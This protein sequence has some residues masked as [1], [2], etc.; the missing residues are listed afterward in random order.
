MKF[1]NKIKLTLLIIF[2]SLIFNFNI[3]FSKNIIIEGNNFIDDEVI[4]SIIGENNFDSNE[5]YINNILK[6]LYNTGNFKNIEIDETSDSIII[7]IEENSRINKISFSGNKRFK[8]D[9]I[10]DQFSDSDYFEF[11]NE[12]R[13]D[14]FINDLK[15]LYLSY[16]YNQIQIEY[17]TVK[18]NDENNSI[19]LIFSFSEGKI[20]KINK[21]FFIGSEFFTKRDFLSEIK[22]NER[23]YFYLFRN[24]NY[25]KFQIKNDLIKIKNFYQKNGFRDVNINYKSEYLESKNRFNVYFYIEE[26]QRY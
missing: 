19:E 14:K 13:I 23:N 22:S 17:K 12:I 18:N 15:N 4:Y 11:Y 9:I 10:L 20:S 1:M 24:E 6:I 25:K 3:A 2:I 5:I 26:G 16:G 21:I 8:K 7:K